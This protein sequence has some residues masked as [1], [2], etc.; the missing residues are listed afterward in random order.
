ML[1]L[2]AG[3]MQQI[4]I[5]AVLGPI[6]FSFLATRCSQQNSEPASFIGTIL[7]KLQVYML[8]VPGSMVSTCCHHCGKRDKESCRN[9]TTKVSM[10]VVSPDVVAIT[11]F[12]Q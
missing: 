6:F 3:C 1:L 12:P 4:Y 2:I 7:F 11:V 5:M 8:C 10:G 9:I